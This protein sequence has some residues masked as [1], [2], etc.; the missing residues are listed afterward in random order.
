[1]PSNHSLPTNCRFERYDAEDEWSFPDQFDY[2]HGRALLSCFKDPAY[3]LQQAYKTLAPGGFLEIQDIVFPFE[4]LGDPPPESPL[5]KWGQIITEGAANLGRPWTNVQYY[6]CWME[7]IEFEGVV[8]K[9]FYWPVNSWAK[10]PFYKQ[11][12]VYAQADFLNALEG[13]SL[14]VMGSMGWSA[15]EVRAFL[16][17]VKRDVE[18][19]SVHC[20]FIMKVVYGRKPVTSQ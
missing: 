20:Y 6:K 9:T 10:G 11:I 18:N 2:I 4:F 19:T 17:K 8:E 13:L 7:E 16:E 5:Y 15:G 12:C 14:K 1:M 3:V